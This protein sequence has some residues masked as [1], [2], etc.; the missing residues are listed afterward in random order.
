MI[1]RQKLTVFYSI[2]AMYDR[3]VHFKITCCFIL[4][5]NYVPIP[6]RGP[7]G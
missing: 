3:Y 7:R 6:V 5:S 1:Q 4:M 2:D